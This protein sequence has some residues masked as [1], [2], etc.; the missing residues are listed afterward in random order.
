M[1]DFTWVPEDGSGI[2]QRFVSANGLRFELAEAGEATSRR[3]ALCLHGFP[4]LNYS[5]RFQMPM[6]AARGW[7]VWAPNLRGY[8][9]SSKPEGVRAYA[10]DHLTDDVA[11]LRQR[12]RESGMRGSATELL[13]GSARTAQPASTQA[14]LHEV[15]RR[16]RRFAEYTRLK[17]RHVA[18]AFA[19]RVRDARVETMDRWT[20]GK[21]RESGSAPHM[22]R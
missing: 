20:A 13:E 18:G 19:E 2:R 17:A 21:G 6:L 10:L 14:R 8:G 5:W 22:D 11:A 3:L 9:A 7:R 16:S 12:V 15:A 1:S 4:E